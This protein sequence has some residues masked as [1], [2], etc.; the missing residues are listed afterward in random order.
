MQDWPPHRLRLRLPEPGYPLKLTRSSP[1]SGFHRLHWATPHT[2][3]PTGSIS[4]LWATVT[5][6]PSSPNTSTLPDLIWQFW[7]EPFRKRI[8][9][10]KRNHFDFKIKYTNLLN[11]ICRFLLIYTVFSISCQLLIIAKW[12]ILSSYIYIYIY[13]YIFLLLNLL[14]KLRY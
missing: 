11:G 1:H 8:M 9:E 5:L 3:H 13:I 12:S 10:G 7:T 14:L 6:P 4:L 2:Q